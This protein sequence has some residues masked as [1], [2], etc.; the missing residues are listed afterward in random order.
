M[1]WAF[2]VVS[3]YLGEIAVCNDVWCNAV[4]YSIDFVIFNGIFDELAKIVDV[5]PW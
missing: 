4:Q 5:N 1:Q 3:S 2:I